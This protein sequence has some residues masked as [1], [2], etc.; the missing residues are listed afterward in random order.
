MRKVLVGGCFDLL[1]FGHLRFLQKARQAGDYLIVAL[2]PDQS[3][4]KI[5]GL[6][7]PIHNTR[8]RRQILEALKSVD[9]VIVLKPG[10]T[11]ADYLKLV[12]R[13]KPAVIAV[14]AGDRQLQNKKR[15]AKKI[16]AVVKIV[17]PKIAGYST[18][19]ILKKLTLLLK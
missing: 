8:Q 9:K 7:R 14:T 15:Q 19:A 10:M 17:T 3:I 5:K 11:D 4:K 1:H 13:I 18:T 12:L 6:D 16:G 2:E